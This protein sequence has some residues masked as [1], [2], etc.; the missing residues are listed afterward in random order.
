[1]HAAVYL[2]SV[3]YCNIY[4]NNITETLFAGV[5]LHSSSDNSVFG[6]IFK[7]NKGFSILCHSARHNS[8]YGNSFLG[9]AYC[10]ELWQSHFTEIFGNIFTG[11][12]GCTIE[13]WSS[14]NNTIFGNT[15]INNRDGVAL[16]SSSNNYIYHNNFVNNTNQFLVDGSPNFWDDGYPSGGNYWSDYFGMDLYSGPYQNETGSDG[17]GDTPYVIDENNID[18]YPLMHPY[19]PLTVSITPSTAEIKIGESVSF[20][21]EVSGG[22]PPYFYQWYVNGNAVEG[23]TSHSWTFTP[24]TLGT[25]IIHLNVT[26]SIPQTAKSNIGTV[27]VAP[28]LETS[29]SPASASILVG[30]S[31]TFTSTVSGGYSPY[32]YQWYLNGNPVSGA[33]SVT[34]T[35]TP[36]ASGIYYVYL[37]VTDDN[38]N[39]VQSDTARITVSTVPVGGYSISI[40][41]PATAKHL[42]PYVILTAI[43]TITYTTIKH[44]TNKK[45]KTPK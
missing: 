29:I 4:R 39:T 8:I 31:I 17:I 12:D 14:S 18:H 33:T 7:A 30:Q 3:K 37:K 44:K 45:N 24:A 36:T 34:W 23:A 1:M 35:F 40:Q 25:Y 15:L 16:V 43:L 20:T 10:V 21:S 19:T 6:N 41:T 22:L 9:N 28:P 11:N 2:D 42:A 13:L 5:N 38:G 32:N 26:D 27:T